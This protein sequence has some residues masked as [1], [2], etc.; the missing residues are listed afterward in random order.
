MERGISMEQN[1]GKSIYRTLAV[2]LAVA[3]I[4]VVVCCGL[5][6]YVF[7]GSESTDQKVAD[8]AQLKI[9]APAKSD[10]KVSESVSVT[11]EGYVKS[12]DKKEEEEEEKEEEDKDK[13]KDDDEKDTEELT[14]DYICPDSATKLLTESDI[15]GLSAQELNYAKNEIYARHGRKFSSQ[16]LQDYFNSKS[17]YKGIYDP[18][19]FD[20]NYSGTVLSEIEKKNAELL[21]NAENK[22]VSGGYQLDD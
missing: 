1:V 19:D 11:A 4:I 13:D 20:Q 21:W 14:D 12:G 8:T 15:S 5:I 6:M 9:V 16:E 7:D 17:W 22:K 3:I 10:L 18:T 2:V